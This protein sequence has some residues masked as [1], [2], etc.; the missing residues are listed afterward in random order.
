[1]FKR[2]WIRKTKKL[3]DINKQKLDLET[4]IS[5]DSALIST[6]QIQLLDLKSKR[7]NNKQ[8]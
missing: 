7:I 5:K 1:M 3:A 2:K 8:F 6:L 4:G